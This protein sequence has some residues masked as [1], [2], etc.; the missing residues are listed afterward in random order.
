LPVAALLTGATVWGLI[1][2]PYRSLLQQGIS[3]ELATTLTYT[4]ALLCTAPFLRILHGEAGAFWLL[5]AIGLSTGGANVGFMIAVIHGDV[6]RVV[7]LFYLAPV[8]T[9]I[10]ARLI[11]QEALSRT[12][13]GLIALA[14]AGAFTILWVPQMGVP[15]PRSS[16]EW[17]GAG[18]GFLFALSNVLV[19]KAGDYPIVVRTVSVFVGCVLVGCAWFVWAG[20]PAGAEWTAVAAQ[21]YFLLLVALVLVAVNVAVQFGLSRVPAN[22]AIVIYLFELLVTAV[23]A[24][25]LAG[26]VMTLKDWA[27][28]GM[29]V[30]AGLWSNRVAEAGTTPAQGEEEARQAQP[31]R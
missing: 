17:F 27:G 21:A 20:L 25:L 15:L 12:G 7:L 6:M 8:W 9:V 30:A 3:G 5:A 4:L 11:L 22:R 28:G 23:S 19:R 31:A 24:W 18:A 2:Y 13:C 16:A 1:W 10:L 26:E 29:I 14:L